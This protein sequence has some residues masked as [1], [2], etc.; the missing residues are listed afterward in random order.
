M[1]PDLVTEIRSDALT[2][3]RCR[4]ICDACNALTDGI[5]FGYRS[6]RKRFRRRWFLVSMELHDHLAESAD[7]DAPTWDLEPEGRKRLASTLELLCELIPEP[8]RFS[9]IWIG[10]DSDERQIGRAE[11]LAVVER[12]AVGTHTTYVVGG[13]DQERLTR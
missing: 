11:L 1:T 13:A 7:W 9:S 5:P 2:R 8:F 6:E 12:D 10:D 4:A 3:E